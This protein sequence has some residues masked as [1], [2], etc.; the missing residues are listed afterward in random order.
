MVASS[1]TGVSGPGNSGKATTNELSR[2]ANAPSILIADVITANGN[3][4]PPTSPPSESLTEVVFPVP[5]DGVGEDYCVLLTTIGGGA[6]YVA[7]LTDDDLDGD[8]ED[9]HF[10]GFVLSADYDSDVMYMVV[11]RGIKSL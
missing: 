1:V 2:W 5:L 9:D 11:K 10:T 3:A 6:A 8:G 4:T 7:S